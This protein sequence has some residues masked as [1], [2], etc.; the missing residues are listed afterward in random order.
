MSKTY[1]GNWPNPLDF[2]RIPEAGS[3]TGS[4]LRFQPSSRLFLSPKS[5]F[6]YGYRFRNTFRSQFQW[7]ITTI[8]N[9][10]YTL[11]SAAITKTLIAQSLNR[12][13]GWNSLTEFSD[14]M[15]LLNVKNFSSIIAKIQFLINYN[16]RI[17][18][19]NLHWNNHQKP[20]FHLLFF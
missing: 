16:H 10:S 3:R 1:G 17:E 18:I 12:L 19:M 4:G 13:W 20:S 7:I 14:S 9:S 8:P 11:V 6:G 15:Q 2:P 5:M